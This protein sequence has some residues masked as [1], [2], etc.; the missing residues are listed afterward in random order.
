VAF[1]PP[2]RYRIN[3]PGFGLKIIQADFV[4]LEN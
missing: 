2:D 3:F 1:L 4:T